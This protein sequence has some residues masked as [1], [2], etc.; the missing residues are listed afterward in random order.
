MKKLLLIGC[1]ILLTACQSAT[2]TPAPSLFPTSTPLPSPIPATFPP[3]PTLTPA[4]SPTPFPRL[5]TNEFDASLEGWAILQA[6][7][8]SVPNIKTENGTLVLEMDSPFTW[9]YGLYGAQDYSDIHV[10]TQFTS[11]ALNPSS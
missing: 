10:D 3:E 7:N 1:L 2:A 6:G 5:F 11:R 8:E 4:P 9:L